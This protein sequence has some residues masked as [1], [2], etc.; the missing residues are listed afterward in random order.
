M[1]RDTK[2]NLIY[3]RFPNEFIP[4]SIG[5]KYDALLRKHQSPYKSTIEFL[6]SLVINITFPSVSYDTVQ[7]TSGLRNPR[8]FRGGLPIT[9]S[10]TKEFSLD[11][12][13]TEGYTSYFILYELLL[14]WNT[15][16]EASK[17]YLPEFMFKTLDLRGYEISTIS[18]TN[19]LFT[20]I[21][22]LALSYS[23]TTPTF[24]TFSINFIANDVD[25]KPNLKTL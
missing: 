18:F 4:Q 16:T 19:I 17:Q 8:N 15:N 3:F 7:Q 2:N 9:Q 12:R 21:G 23:D 6:N 22:E 10:I 25:I 5:D 13:L 11:I 1:Y 24:N 20:G 14:Y